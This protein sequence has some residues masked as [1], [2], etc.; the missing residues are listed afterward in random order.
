[1]RIGIY[2]GP[3]VAGVMGKKK[4]TYDLWGDAVNTASRMESHGIP[5]IVHI[6]ESTYKHIKGKFNIEC[7]GMID[8]KG[9]G[10]MKTYILKHTADQAFDRDYIHKK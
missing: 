4:F 8:V 6:S 5:G 3:V 10:E 7:R 1:M 9:K 2:T